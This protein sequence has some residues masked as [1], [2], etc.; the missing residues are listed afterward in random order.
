MMITRDC[1]LNLN[2]F[3]KAYI[4]ECNITIIELGIIEFVLLVLYRYSN[5]IVIL[6]INELYIWLVVLL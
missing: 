5:N 6:Y 3:N 2:S 1:I 4:I